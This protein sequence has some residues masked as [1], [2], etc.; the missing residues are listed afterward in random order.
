[1]LPTPRLLALLAL[2]AALLA[3]ASAVPGLLVL[4]VL[5]W[6]AALAL[7]GAEWRLTPD[8]ALAVGRR[9]EPR[10]SLGADNLVW[11]DVENRTGRA[12]AVTLRDAVPPSCVA[13]AEFVRGLVPAHRQASLRYTLRPLR[14]GDHKLGDVTARWRGPLGLLDRQESYPLAEL[15]KVYPNLLDLR[16]YDLLVRRGRLVEAGL[17]ASRRFDSGT[18]FES[19]RD[20]QPDDDYRR[21]NWKATA[22]RGHPM[23]AEFETERSQNVLVMLDAGRLM[24]TAVGALN[25]LDHAVNTSLLLAYVAGLRGDRVGMLAFADRVLAYLPPRRGKRPFYVMLEALYNLEP[26]PVEPD[27][28]AVFRFLAARSLRRSLLVVFTDL[29]D[30]DVSSSLVQHLARLARHHLALCVTLGDPQVV[31]LAEATPASTAALYE[32]VVA[33]RLLEERAE[34]LGALRRRGVLTLDVPA[35][36]LSVAVVNKYL[37]LKART[38]I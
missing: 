4:A 24:S 26:E 14:R 15:V 32:R 11:L 29:T 25:K 23:T 22:R 1:M 19:L 2:P 31:A 30:R 13:S 16:K 36:R 6:L 20:Y 37:E 35:D 12:L 18:E 10:L 9:H 28:D 5:G 33:G 38:R 17:R 3:A 27:F 34:V 21:I 7:V 8:G